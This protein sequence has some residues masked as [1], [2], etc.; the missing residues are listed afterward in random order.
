M[1]VPERY[2]GVTYAGS[3]LARA[4][5][6][7]NALTVPGFTA[8]YYWTRAG[9]SSAYGQAAYGGRAAVSY[10]AAGLL[11]SPDPDSATAT[12]WVWW[13]FASEVILTRVD[14]DGTRVPV[15]SSPVRLDPAKSRRNYATNPKARDTLTGYT[16]DA[17]TTIDRLTGQTTPSEYVTAAL[18]LT[19]DVAGDVSVSMTGEPVGPVAT[20]H[21][22]WAKTSA[23]VSDLYLQ[24]QWYDK[25]SLSLG[26]QTY[27]TGDV[28]RE[29][30]VG[31]W[32]WCEVTIDSWPASAVVGVLS[33]GAAGVAA[34][35]TV[36]IT[37]RLTETGEALGGGYFD[38]DFPASAWSGDPGLSYSDTSAIAY[39]I[40]AEA[41]LDTPVRYEISSGRAP[42]YAASTLDVVVPGDRFRSPYDALLTHPGLAKTVPVWIEADPEITNTIEQGQFQVIGRR[43][44]VVIS[45]PQRAGDEGSLTFVC[46]TLEQ[47]RELRAM[48]D[49]GSP[50]LLRAKGG[51][52]KPPNWWLAFGDLTVTPPTSG[53]ANS[54][55]EV[56]RLTASFVEVD[57]PSAATRPLAA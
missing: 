13:A 24:V 43:N 23:L 46:E 47:R 32:S 53:A 20:S 38:G 10:P 4:G 42:G 41:P 50:L 26:T 19:A 2:G 29:Q 31:A 49:D 14:A 45:A 6:P 9:S 35:G 54:T 11:A 28:A 57:R 25:D 56:R 44:K 1:A 55:G 15:R 8:I 51:Y 33:L 3:P 36:D 7:G 22:F 27:P 30:A 39:V 37:G 21:G 17:N 52:G 12:I 16:A 40:D 18:R 5:L 34:S 48:L